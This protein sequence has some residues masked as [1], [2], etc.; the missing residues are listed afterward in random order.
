MRFLQPELTDRHTEREG[1]TVHAYHCK[2]I[3]S[4]H[5]FYGKSVCVC[6]L[7]EVN[8]SPSPRSKRIS[9]CL[10]TENWIFRQTTEKKICLLK[11]FID[12]NTSL[13]N[14][15]K[16]TN[17]AK[18]KLFAFFEMFIWEHIRTNT[19]AELPYVYPLLICCRDIKTI[20]IYSSQWRCFFGHTPKS[21]SPCAEMNGIWIEKLIRIV[22]LTIQ[23]QLL[24]VYQRNAYAALYINEQSRWIVF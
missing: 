24:H 21:D 16:T 19:S 23:R 18:L 14:K 4:I 15:K 17:F 20:I 1:E 13:R 9:N 3:V 6:A 22:L 5:I 2:C 7:C 11:C 8:L 10:L 12:E